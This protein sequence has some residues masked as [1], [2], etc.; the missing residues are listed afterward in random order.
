MIQYVTQANLVLLCQEHNVRP[1]WYWNLTPSYDFM[2]RIS[3]PDQFAAYLLAQLM[4]LRLWAPRQNVFLLQLPF[5][6][7]VSKFNI[8]S[9]SPANLAGQ[10][11]WK[12][13]IRTN[14]LNHRVLACL[15]VRKANLLFVYSSSSSSSSSSRY[16]IGP[17]E[18]ESLVWLSLSLSG[19]TVTSG[20]SVFTLRPCCFSDRP[21]ADL[22]NEITNF[23]LTKDNSNKNNLQ[24]TLKCRR[25]SR[26][27]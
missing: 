20:C 12:R 17:S 19:I 2:K 8:E 22:Q 1:V 4:P 23:G 26:S 27:L 14:E 5:A 9:V 13:Q 15:T 3:V 10:R 21:F 24:Q 25:K 7:S 16:K 6:G 11:A 18:S